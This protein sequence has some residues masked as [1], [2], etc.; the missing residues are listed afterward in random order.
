MK[1]KRRNITMNKK[2]ST[3]K[4]IIFILL[5]ALC[6]SLNDLSPFLNATEHMRRVDITGAQAVE[7]SEPDVIYVLNCGDSFTMNGENGK[8]PIEVPKRVSGSHNYFLEINGNLTVNGINATYNNPS[9]A[10]I[11]IPESEHLTITG[12]GSLTANGGNGINGQDAQKDPNMK[13]EIHA[14]KENERLG[15]KGGGGGSAGIGGNGGA[16]GESNSKPGSNGESAGK[17]TIEGKNFT[18][19]ARGGAGGNGGTGGLGRGSAFAPAGLFSILESGSG[20]GGG[21]GGGFPAAAIGGGG[22]GGGAGGDGGML[23]KILVAI[24]DYD[25]ADGGSGG[26]GGAGYGPGSGGNAGKDVSVTSV[27]VPVPVLDPTHNRSQFFAQAGQEG[28]DGKEYDIGGPS[29]QWSGQAGTG[30]KS[31]FTPGKGGDESGSSWD[32]GINSKDGFDG[33]KAGKNGDGGESVFQNA[34]VILNHSIQLTNNVASGTDSIGAGGGTSKGYSTTVRKMYQMEDDIT[35]SLTPVTRTY[36]GSAVVPVITATAFDGTIITPDSYLVKYPNDLINVGKKEVEVSGKE[37]QISKY[38]VKGTSKIGFEVTKGVFESI[39]SFSSP[40]A[41][42]D[43]PFTAS[44][45]NNQSGGVINWVVDDD[46][47]EVELSSTQGSSIQV[48]PKAVGIVKLHAVVAETPNYNEVV[49]KTKAIEVF[50]LGVDNFIVEGIVDKEYTGNA[51]SQDGLVVKMK[52]KTLVLDQDYTV[53]YT[54]NVNIGE[55][56]MQIK[57]IGLYSGVIDTT[58]YIGKANINKTIVTA[59]SNLIYTGNSQT[60]K[61]VVVFNG[62][63]LVEDVDY[64]L[65]YSEYFSGDVIVSIVGEGNFTGTIETTYKIAPV[66]INTLSDYIIEDISDVMYNGNPQTPSLRV[67]FLGR[68]LNENTDYTVDYTSNVN[69]GEATAT[70]HA[71]GNFTG[72]MSKTFTITTAPVS[73]I[74]DAGK[75]KYLGGVDP[76][77]TFTSTGALQGDV[78][79]F[80]SQTKLTRDDGEALGSYAIK[81]DGLKLTNAPVNKNYHLVMDVIESFEIKEYTTSEEAT[82]SGTMGKDGWYYKE[83]VHIIAPD[84]FSISISNK[85]DGEWNRYVCVPDGDYSV[86]GA[87]YYIKNND[88]GFISQIKSIKFKQDTNAPVSRIEINKSKSWTGMYATPSFKTFFQKA[89]DVSVFGDDDHSKTDQVDYY[90]SEQILDEQ[91]L[92]NLSESSWKDSDEFKITID[93]KYIVYARVSDKA[94]N[95]GYGRSDGFIIDNKTP[96]ITYVYESENAWTSKAQPD[97][98]V[99]ISDTLSGLMDRYVD[100]EI[101]GDIQLLELTNNQAQIKNLPDGAYTLTI[102]AKDRANNIYTVPVEVKKDTQK[103]IIEVSGNTVDYAI[104]QDVNINTIVGAS[105]I[106]KVFMKYVAADDVFDEAAPWDDITD[107]YL[108]NQ[109]YNALKNGTYYF[110]VESVVGLTSDIT[111]ISF[112]HLDDRKPVIDVSAITEDKKVYTSDVWTNKKVTTTFKNITNNLGESIYEYKLDDGS[113]IAITPVDTLCSLQQATQGKHTYTFRIT[114]NAGVVSDEVSFKVNI[115]HILPMGSIAIEDNTWTQFLSVITGNIFYNHDSEI[116]ASGGD[117]DSGINEIKVFSFQS[118]DKDF[119]KKLPTTIEEVE[120]FVNDHGG[121][122]D[123]NSYPIQVNEKYNVAY[124]KV[125]DKAGNVTYV[126]SDGFVLDSQ[127]PIIETRFTGSS[128]FGA[129]GTWITKKENKVEVEFRDTLS[130]MK[131]FD[132]TL[133]SEDKVVGNADSFELANLGNGIY[134]L[135]INAKDNAGNT[136]NLTLDLQV[137]FVRPDVKLAKGSTVDYASYQD[138]LIEP[139]VGCSGIKKVETQFVPEGA[140]YSDNNWVDVTNTYQ[141]GDKITK[142]GTYYARMQNNLGEPSEIKTWV[143]DKITFLVPEIEAWTLD[144]D[145][146]KVKDEQ[147]LNEDATIAFANNPHNVKNFVYEYQIGLSETWI[148][149]MADDKGIARIPADQIPEGQIN[150]RVRIGNKNSSGDYVY[151]ETTKN[152]WI[153]RTKA[154][155]VLRLGDIDANEEIVNEVQTN[156][157]FEQ[158]NAIKNFYNTE[159]SF[160][161]DNVQDSAGNTNSGVKNISYY[162]QRSNEGEYLSD[163]PKKEEDVEPFINNRWTTLSRTAWEDGY[164]SSSFMKKIRDLSMKRSY[165]MYVKLEDNAGNITYI[166]SEGLAIDNTKPEIS[167]DYNKDKWISDDNQVITVTLTK[168][169]GGMKQGWY[170]INGV[171][172]I[173]NESDIINK[174]KFEIPMQ[175]LIEGKNDLRVGAENILGNGAD[176]I[177]AIISKDTKKPDIEVVGNI[178][179]YA[180][181]QN[182]ELRPDVGVSQLKKVEMSTDGTTWNDITNS[183]EGGYLAEKN[184]TYSFR[185]TNYALVTSD[186]RSITFDRIDNNPPIVIVDAE[187]DDGTYEQGIWTNRPVDIHV[188]NKQHNYGIST[189]F[190]NKDQLEVQN[191]KAR[192]INTRAQ[193]EWVAFGTTTSPS[194]I[195]SVTET[196]I[197]DHLY[198]FVIESQLGLRSNLRPVNVRIDKQSPE[199]SASESN[200]SWSN[201][202]SSVTI[203]A[204][205]DLSGFGIDAYS[206]DGGKTF[207]NSPRGEISQNQVVDIVVKDQA[208]NTAMTNAEVTHI[209]KLKPMIENAKQDSNE[210]KKSKRVSATITDAQ[211]DSKNGSSGIN[212]VFLT[213][214][215]PYKGNEIARVEPADDDIIM[216]DVAGTGVFET[217]KPITKYIGED[218]DD[219]FWIVVLDEANNV[220]ATSLC[221]NKVNLENK[222]EKPEKPEKPDKPGK[223]GDPSNPDDPSKPDDLDKPDN[224]G[225]PSP[226][227]PGDSD[228]ENSGKPGSG[229]GGTE[230]PGY[231]DIID[232]I[233]NINTPKGDKPSDN[234]KNEITDLLDKIEEALKHGDLTKEEKEALLKEKDNLLA[235]LIKMIDEDKDINTR[236]KMKANLS[237]IDKLLKRDDLTNAQR[238]TLEKN[239]DLLN[240]KLSKLGLSDEEKLLVSFILIAIVISLI[241]LT[242]ALYFRKKRK[243]IESKMYTN[244]EEIEEQ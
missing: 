110:M 225:K 190:Y 234:V 116:K 132:Y 165:I 31:D 91:D 8:P 167:L 240:N 194:Q 237:Y 236:D 185:V 136:E 227:Q 107:D 70:L 44:L 232:E 150:I 197:G 169:L 35:L 195:V 113:W 59:P 89:A 176:S 101:N 147:W 243:R 99:T 27:A 163:F 97:F 92:K 60:S 36:D 114:S 49:T 216:R 168:S 109:T 218:T 235:M 72:E 65:A 5:S 39:L 177:S 212:A 210:W 206:F 7:L 156:T 124:A 87:T 162:L 157:A 71:L 50:P 37:N 133:D 9:T 98:T 160:F 178:E 29:G 125:S 203:R 26:G 192:K 68:T 78:P 34:R 58:F 106:K 75:W 127:K 94:G 233:G 108:D 211:A 149:I 2:K 69:A 226:G 22:A 20:G 126:S 80:D 46:S 54:N 84:G 51:I 172:K 193:E 207:M 217:S 55:A 1:W 209:D 164:E 123:T 145:G 100:Y 213:S 19:N 115:D 47:A 171:K 57:G 202:T 24:I 38:F 200:T 41:T 30:A 229:S 111:S 17:L 231:G 18:V 208:G 223:P 73:V 205:D 61:P 93:G 21:G 95:L 142:R 186:V 230:L 152:I 102:N 63:Q 121:W 181:K 131:E 191:S 241:S 244:E 214:H 112:T 79:I 83:P 66:D 135:D 138:I 64:S 52:D 175:S 141:N 96:D 151:S 103:P 76:A 128:D 62:T 120:D 48:T 154:T 129:L 189:Y 23:I 179:E 118:N 146:E 204:K 215:N 173:V 10:G 183:F 180:L 199:V 221:V 33:G 3:N 82:L 137:D 219:N 12:N 153:D 32:T 187:L 16:G 6:I 184:G 81:L 143:F 85:A 117:D 161:L 40:T 182:I 130:G 77:F 140:T 166:S 53:E 90:L 220:S 122:V 4:L 43:K 104:N 56:N 67:Q 42:I 224:G 196:D 174:M 105:G 158:N 25:R 13:I 14:N 139:I 74:P 170:E 45:S 28:K 228:D 86:D 222:P 188:R 88:N 144:R 119:M 134:E 15:G 238:T 201:T 159:K 198:K 242:S 239:R 148:S 155:G 11:H